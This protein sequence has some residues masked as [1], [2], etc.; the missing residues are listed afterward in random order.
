MI[1]LAYVAAAFMLSTLQVL[2]AWDLFR[3]QRLQVA[4]SLQA[5]SFLSFPRSSNTRL[6]HADDV[7]RTMV[8]GAN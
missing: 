5:A 4:S 6:V 8:C 2:A 1:F 7:P 3:V